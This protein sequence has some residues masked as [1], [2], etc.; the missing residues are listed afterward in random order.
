ANAVVV[1]AIEG[2]AGVGKT[3]LAIHAAHQLVRDGYFTDIQLHVNLRG[4]DPEHPPADPSAVLE[5][6]LRQLGVPAQ[7]IPTARDERA[8]MYRDRLRKR[9]AVVLLD[10]AADEDQVRDLIPAGPSCLVL[11]TSR[12]SLAGLDGVNPHLIGTFSEAES[13][14]LLIQ[15]AGRDRIEAEPEAA[16]RVVQYCGHL[17]LALA[18]AASRLRSRPSWS[19]AE[20]ADRLSDGQLGAI[21]AGGRA[22]RPVFE[23]SYRELAEPLRRVFR[24]LGHHPGPDFTPAMVAALAD[25]STHE[26][27]DALEALQDENLVRQS[28]P[29][30]YELHDLLRA[31]ALDMAVDDPEVQRPAVLD[32]LARWFLHS[33]YGAATAMN[34]PG[35]PQ[36]APAAGIAPLRFE[37]YEAALRWFDVE[38]Q[39]LIAVHDAAAQEELYETTWQLPIVLDSFRN[40]RFHRTQ[41]VT[42]HRIA[43]RAARA[44]GDNL[45]VA[46]NLRGAAASL[47]ELTRLD[48]A[49]TA[50]TEALGLYQGAHDRR[51]ESAALLDLGRHYLLRNQYDKAIE[52]LSRSIEFNESVGDRR[53][54]MICELNLGA[55]Y[56]LLDDL[57]SASAY[58]GRALT[59]ARA[60][61]ERRGEC[62]TLGNLGELSLR[63]G[64]AR[65]ARAYY[66]DQQQVA[67]EIGAIDLHGTALAGLGD[68]L[69]AMG[70]LDRARSYW[71]EAHAVFSKIES[72]EAERVQE[73]IWNSEAAEDHEPRAAS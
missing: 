15:I 24:V 28:T 13:L 36:L 10:N 30:R 26:A 45:V 54:V 20:L 58:F 67:E 14:D 33:A 4:F 21:R 71:Q 1:S 37:S 41:S 46:W 66:L 29:G 16:A 32:R 18:L 53:R 62:L 31:Y 59:S 8:A 39:N 12:R 43:V 42:A 51:G 60:V 34:A 61:G 68:S 49:E 23:L 64:R 57:D 35:L 48:E 56:Y 19:L 38:H 5:A 55:T 63:L 25:I 6:F 27:E 2:M 40:L 7:Q 9:S 52:A 73:L 47:H 72:P 70:Y 50:L 65:S 3:Q 22:L 11:I 17:P 44:R 69:Q